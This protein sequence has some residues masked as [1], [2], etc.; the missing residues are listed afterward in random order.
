MDDTWTSFDEVIEKIRTEVDKAKEFATDKF[1]VVESTNLRVFESKTY[2]DY[3]D[4]PR[5]CHMQFF[6]QV[7][8]PFGIYN[9][10]VYRH[11]PQ[12][13]MGNNQAY[14]GSENFAKTK[15]KVAELIKS[16][17]ASKEC[18]E[19]TCLYN[20]ANWFIEDLIENPH[21][22][23]SLEATPEREDYFL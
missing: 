7:V 1:Q 2:R 3:T 20:P 18:R 9:C 13:M 5:N 10:P 17:D 19:V 16:F 6:R 21:K 11:V 22:L 14:A 4:Q 12:A 23:D 15:V 8:S